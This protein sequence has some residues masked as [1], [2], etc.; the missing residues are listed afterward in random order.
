LWI[1]HVISHKPGFLLLSY[2]YLLL[3][4][5]V[6]L[7]VIIAS[8]LFVNLPANIVNILDQDS[9]NLNFLNK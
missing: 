6:F 2:F 1:C 5:S 8:F 4:I 3:I 9:V 7:R